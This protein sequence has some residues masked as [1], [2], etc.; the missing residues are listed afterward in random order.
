MHH[1]CLMAGVVVNPWNLCRGEIADFLVA[2][3]GF[4]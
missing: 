2:Q 4:A 3:A 1:L